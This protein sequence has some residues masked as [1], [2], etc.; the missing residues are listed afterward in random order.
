MSDIHVVNLLCLSFPLMLDV[1]EV[2]EAEVE[3]EE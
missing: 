3:E 2:V 1:E